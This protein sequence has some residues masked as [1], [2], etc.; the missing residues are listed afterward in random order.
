MANFRTRADRFGSLML[1][2]TLVGLAIGSA[3]TKT[4][5]VAVLAKLE[6]KG[7]RA[8]ATPRGRK[9]AA[10]TAMT[11]LRR[12]ILSTATSFLSTKKVL[13][14]EVLPGRPRGCGGRSHRGRR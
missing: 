10:A 4:R 9:S 12:R 14:L 2:L 6:R 8:A 3:A 1:V 7:T 13:H 11:S 5:A